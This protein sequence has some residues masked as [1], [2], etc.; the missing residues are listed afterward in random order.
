MAV[1]EQLAHGM[2]ARGGAPRGNDSVGSRDCGNGGVRDQRDCKGWNPS[3][4]MSLKLIAGYAQEPWFTAIVCSLGTWEAD[5]NTVI[6]QS[7]GETVMA[8]GPPPPGSRDP[9]TAVSSSSERWFELAQMGTT[10][11]CFE[12]FA[13]T[14]AGFRRLAF[15]CSHGIGCLVRWPVEHP[16]RAIFL[17]P[18]LRSAV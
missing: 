12:R 14:D 1:E 7:M 18:L 4:N 9:Q 5:R 17:D 3:S 2:G 16:S 11:P 15:I 13:R 8:A 6:L 10:Y